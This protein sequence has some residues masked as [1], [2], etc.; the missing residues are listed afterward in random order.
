MRILLVHNEYG[1]LS[2][3]DVMV[4]SI[5]RLLAEHGHE[6]RGYYRSSRGIDQAAH[7]KVNAFFSGIYSHKS[8]MELRG[9][10]KDF[11]P[12]LI[13]V[14]NVYPLISP[15]VFVEA[16]AMGVPVV[17]RCANYRL[18]CPNGLMMTQ[19]EI[20]DRCS[21]GREWWCLLRNCE[22]SWPKSLGYALR[23][24][25][26]R[27]KRMVL[28]HTT[29]YYVPTKF[30]RNRMIAEGLPEDRISVIPNLLETVD[31]PP[32]SESGDFVGYAGRISPEKGIETFT[33]AAR[34]ARDIAFRAAG[35]C[36]RML[37]LPTEAP[38]NCGFLGH[39]DGEALDTFYRACRMLVLP[40]VCY[41]SFGLVLL[42]A[43][44]RGKPVICSNLGGLSETVEDGVTGLL[45]DSG[46]PTDLAQKI[47]YLWDHPGLCRKMGQ[48]GREKVLREYS[49]ER[50][51][52]R[53]TALYEKTLTLAATREEL[54]V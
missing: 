29:T 49:P 2:G 10:I 16:H 41:E 31:V 26:A 17:M 32:A 52:E 40:S 42:E 43:M 20:C 53:L 23:N 19:G 21:G 18:I 24:Y 44:I 11:E 22:G 30:H 1:R 5:A 13:Q 9:I 3:E 46:N 7:R 15:S 14:Q 45:F 6:V 27:T 39:L 25:V 37:E 28:D 38:S 8:R 50:Y 34:L 35:S 51:Y 4:A 36:E 47:R 48:A 33:A 54:C 12:D